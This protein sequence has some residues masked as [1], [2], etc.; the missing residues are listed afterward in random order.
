MAALF[1]PR[2]NDLPPDLLIPLGS[3]VRGRIPACDT[4]KE[5]LEQLWL[6][7]LPLLPIQNCLI[8]QPLHRIKRERDREYGRHWKPLR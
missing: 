4:A 1:L 3:P 2:A 8:F 5:W 7:L 6:A